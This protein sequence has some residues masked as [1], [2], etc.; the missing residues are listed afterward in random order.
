M[1]NR[2]L[3]KGKIHNKLSFS[4]AML[5]YQRVHQ[6]VKTCPRSTEA[7]SSVK[8]ASTV[9]LPTVKYE[10]L[11]A[12]V[13]EGCQQIE[14]DVLSWSIMIYHGV[15]TKNRL[16]PKKNSPLSQRRLYPI[17]RHTHISYVF[18]SCLCFALF[19]LPNTPLVLDDNDVKAD[20][21][22]HQTYHVHVKSSTCWKFTDKSY[23]RMSNPGHSAKPRDKKLLLK[24]N[25]SS[26]II[27][28]HHLQYIA[29][30]PIHSREKTWTN[31]AVASEVSSTRYI[32]LFAGS[33]VGIAMLR[34]SC[35]VNL[36]WPMP[37]GWA[38]V[39][40]GGKCFFFFTN[41]KLLKKTDL[42]I[43]IYIYMDH[44]IW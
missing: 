9:G 6:I 24:H 33:R 3:F 27:I 8:A 44:I 12:Q 19:H 28:Y 5:S 16:P 18:F 14:M 26:S 43:Y 23:P 11:H 25:L 42:E 41:R 35:R 39:G 34:N 40:P 17:F 29:G 21:N 1:E 37:E 31:P 15:S 32:K 7:K 36:A 30:R 2:H 20:K 38:V 22:I 10:L 4:R 13:L